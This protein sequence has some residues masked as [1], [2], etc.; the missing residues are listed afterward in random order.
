MENKTMN[1]Q[2]KMTLLMHSI[3][4]LQ[5]I[6]EYYDKLIQYL[7]N[8]LIED[9]QLIGYDEIF[10]NININFEFMLKILNETKLLLENV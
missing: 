2:Q 7:K 3:E 4:N 9:F 8:D 10:K 5:Y 1:N 6:N